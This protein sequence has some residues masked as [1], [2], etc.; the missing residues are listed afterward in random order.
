MIIAVTDERGDEPRRVGKTI[1]GCRKFA[2]PVYVLGV[3]APFGRDF[4]YL[5]YVDPDPKY[6]Q[7]EQ[8]GQIDQGPETLL[9][10]R[11]QIGF[12][13]NYYEEPIIDSGFGPY[14]ISRLC[15]ETVVCISPFTP[16]A[17]TTMT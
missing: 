1:E 5:K 3:P 2:I 9:P 14:S 16:I 12:E 17:I 6:D 4:T 11:V 15:Y 8:W 13:N 10:E 7:S